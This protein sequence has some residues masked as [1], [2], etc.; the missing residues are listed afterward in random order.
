[1]TPPPFELCNRDKSPA[2]WLPDLIGAQNANCYK[3][4]N[5]SQFEKVRKSP[6]KWLLD[7][8]GRVSVTI[9]QFHTHA[10]RS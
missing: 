3:K 5:L 4:I 9:A 6:A 7:L 1:M 10:Q 8:I 2:K